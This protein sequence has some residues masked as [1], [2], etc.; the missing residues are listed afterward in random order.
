[1]VTKLSPTRMVSTVMGAWF[2]ATAFSN[3]LAGMI[4]K[5]TGVGHEEGPAQ[6]IPPPAETVDLYGNVFGTI[7]LTAIASAAICFCLA[8]LLGRWTHAGAAA[9]NDGH[10]PA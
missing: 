7:A 10:D 2:L 6:V 9:E 4:A 1:M 5:F 3:Y 8:P